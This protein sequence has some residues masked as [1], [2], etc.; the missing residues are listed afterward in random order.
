MREH[1]CDREWEMG[2]GGESTIFFCF[3][4]R[5]EITVLLPHTG[6]VCFRVRS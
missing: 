2:D 6:A 1:V 3:A 5:R 4:K